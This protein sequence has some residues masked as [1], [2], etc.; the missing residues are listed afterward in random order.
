MARNVTLIVET[1]SLVAGAN[2]F[3]SETQIITYALQRG[4]TLPSSTDEDLDAVAVLG[5]KAMDYLLGLPWRGQPVD[6]AQTTPWPR[7]NLNLT[8]DVPDNVVPRAVIEAQLQLA[9][10]VQAGNDISPIHTGTGFI[11]RDRVGP[12][13][14]IYS[15]KVGVS[16]DGRPIIPV[17]DGLLEPYLLADMDDKVPVIIKSVGAR[18]WP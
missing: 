5:I 10:L 15:E 18:E 8:P 16:T 14:T 2:S 12:I 3:V 6:P 7:K 1:G 17:V 9:L 13:D 4:V 11:V